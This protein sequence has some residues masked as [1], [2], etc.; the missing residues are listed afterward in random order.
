MFPVGDPGSARESGQKIPNECDRVIAFARCGRSGGS[1]IVEVNLN[2]RRV[3]VEISPAGVSM[4]GRQIPCDWT[5]VGEG[6]Y[7]LILN[8]RVFD[9]SVSF[10]DGSFAVTGREGSYILTVSDP[11]TYRAPLGADDPG[12][13]PLRLRADMPGKV[14]RVL[15]TKGDAVTS[16]QALLVLEAMKMQ[17][18]I[19]SPKAGVVKELAVE[20]GRAVSSGDLLVAIE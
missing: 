5:C 3:R 12:E 10:R 8:G 4:D 16:G 19:R 13:G 20:A 17:N 1:V 18:E 15:V 11:D 9:L 2:D 6:Q 7:S 14:I